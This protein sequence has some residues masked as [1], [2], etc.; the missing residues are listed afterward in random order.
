MKP[1]AVPNFKNDLGEIAQAR[2]LTPRSGGVRNVEVTGSEAVITPEPDTSY[3][4]GELTSLTVTDP[5]AAGLWM[6]SFTSGAS[7]SVTAFPA[8]IKG[9][10]DFAA[11]TNTVYEINVLDSRAVVGSWTV[12]AGE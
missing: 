10:D 11:E 6:I 5:P 9:L 4:C 3:H 8:S 12:S 1:Y 7:A 2:L